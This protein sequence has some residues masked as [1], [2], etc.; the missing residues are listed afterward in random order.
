ML[1]KKNVAVLLKEFCNQYKYKW[2]S[3]LKLPEGTHTYVSDARGS[4]SWMDHLISTEDGSNVMTNM[5]VL[6]GTVQSDHIAVAVNIDLQLAPDIDHGAGNNIGNKIDWSALGEDVI[7]EYG[8]QSEIHLRNVEIP[9][10]VLL[11]KDYNCTEV[12]NKEALDKYYD[13]TMCA[14]TS[15]G[16][17]T[18]KIRKPSKGN[19]LNR[20]G[21]NEFASDLYDVSR[22]TY[23]LWQNSGSARQGML[24]YIKKTEQKLGLKVL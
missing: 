5:C 8:I 10:D 18:I 3:C 24:F 17:I 4:H 2:T 12:K 23:I 11:C 19:N 20:P 6:Y 15:A 22:E 1:R 14:I 21:W 9:S 16:Q 7:Y 13:D